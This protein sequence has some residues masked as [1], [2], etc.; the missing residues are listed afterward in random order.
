MCVRQI[1]RRNKSA[2]IEDKKTSANVQAGSDNEFFIEK[3][4][5]FYLHFTY[6]DVNV[7]VAKLIL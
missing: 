5:K 1:V 7:N 2:R 4:H 6:V 3:T